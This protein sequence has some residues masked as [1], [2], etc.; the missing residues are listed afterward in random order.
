MGHLNYDTLFHFNRYIVEPAGVH[1]VKFIAMYFQSS[2]E[3][4][5]GIS[6]YLTFDELTVP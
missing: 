6:G 2:G 5:D 3:C 1:D 4:S